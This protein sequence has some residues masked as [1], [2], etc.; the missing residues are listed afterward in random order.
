MSGFNIRIAY[1]DSDKR[2]SDDPVDHF[3]VNIGQPEIPARI[4][5]RQPL[6]IEAQQMQDGRVQVVE[7]NLVLHRVIAVVVGRSVL[8]DPASRRRPPAT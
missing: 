1:R 2:L 5:I 7:V 3:P 8:Q 4:A 6:V